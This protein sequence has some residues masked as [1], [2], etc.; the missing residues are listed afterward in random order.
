[1]DFKFDKLKELWNEEQNRMYVIGVG[2]L[3]L[4]VLYLSFIIIP[5][6]GEL[7][8]VSR[9]VND[10]NDQIDLVSSR[11][12]KIE[13]TGGKLE[14]L[15][16]EQKS[17]AK[18]LPAEKEIPGLLEG[19]SSMAQRS[20]LNIQSITPY[21]IVAI[22]PKASQDVYYREMPLLVTAKG[23]YHQLGAFISDLAL[24]NRFI[25]IEDLNIQY[26]EKAPRMHNIR[27]LL[28]TY[29][30]VTGA[31]KDKSVTDAAKKIKKK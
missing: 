21:D 28:K 17:Y 10:L 16:E 9:E 7:G 25:T 30:S 29:I 6:V 14:S 13:E 1:M 19:L 12:K 27:M 18:Q 3:V 8:R 4:G 2:T 5:K 11:V 23:G 22:E 20:G 26:D 15:K 24:S 31:A